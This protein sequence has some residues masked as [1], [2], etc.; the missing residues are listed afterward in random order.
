MYVALY[1]DI[2]ELCVFCQMFVD[3]YCLFNPFICII[4]VVK[5]LMDHRGVL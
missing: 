3:I 2:V 4:T 5:L 1:S